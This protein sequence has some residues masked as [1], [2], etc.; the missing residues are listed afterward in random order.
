MADKMASSK[1]FQPLKIGSMA[2][3]HR[4]M[5]AP[6]TRYRALDDHVPMAIV[7]DYYAQRARS[8]PGTLIITE[9]SLISPRAGGYA[10]VPGIW[11]KDQ[12]N[13]WAK[14]VKAIHDAGGYAICQLWA[15]GRAAKAEV[16]TTEPD[17]PFDVVSS[18]NMPIDASS[19]IPRALSIEEIQGFI[20]DYAQAA[21][22]A[23]TAGFDGVEIHM[24]NGYLIDQFTQDT[25]NNR[26]DQYG[27]SVE[28]RARFG[29]EVAKAVLE[30]IGAS[31]VGFRLSP[32]S[33]FQ[34]MRM[35]DNSRLE[36]Q[37]TYLIK[38]LRNLDLAFMHLVE[39]RIG[40]DQDINLKDAESLE[41]AFDAWGSTTNAPI[42]V[43]G[44]YNAS[45]ARQALD[46]NRIYRD[47][48]VAVVFGRWFISN[49]DLPFR[50]QKNIP[51]A[52][53]DRTTFYTPKQEEG[54]NDYPFSLEYLK[55]LV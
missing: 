40:G 7:A 24:A 18:S 29:L 20:Q 46:E 17:G 9:A 54:Y 34:G 48:D 50:I 16:L 14:V 28:N 33:P 35:V 5:M 19:S 32:W 10:N 3:G 30:A 37:F 15:M 8:L 1:L 52:K 49:P 23:I 6:L 21:R 27:G 51:F 47:K 36:E 2:L 31:R 53:Y 25:C 43:A 45:T 22:N 11:S 38:E 39:P 55:T 13:S 4:I 44:G 42:L 12:I 26:T 41:F